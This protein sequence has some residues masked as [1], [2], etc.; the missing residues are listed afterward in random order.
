MGI[1]RIRICNKA[2][3]AIV[4]LV[5]LLGCAGNAYANT[6]SFTGQGVNLK[7]GQTKGL[8]VLMSFDLRGAGCPTGPHCFQNAKVQNFEG[9]SWAFPNCPDVLDGLFQLDTHKAHQVTKSGGHSF[10]ASGPNE[11]YPRAHVSIG[12]RF[13]HHGKTAKGW[14][15]V[16]DLGCSTDVIHWIATPN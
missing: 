2:L 11:E 5:L 9:N 7:P 10:S 16:T 8:P 15:T 3:G 1:R 4:A 6:A 12:G 14:F 13:I